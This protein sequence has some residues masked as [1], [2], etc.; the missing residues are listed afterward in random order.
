MLDSRA[1]RRLQ[2][3]LPV[4]SLVILLESTFILGHALSSFL[5]YLLLFI[6]VLSLNGRNVVRDSTR[7]A[8]G[9]LVSV[10]EK[11]DVVWDGS[12]SFLV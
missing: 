7:F 2:T 10:Y 6:L 1:K 9:R 12:S 3:G 4:P 8:A 11:L 5:V